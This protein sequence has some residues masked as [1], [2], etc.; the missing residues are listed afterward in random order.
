MLKETLFI[1]RHPGRAITAVSTQIAVANEFQS[2]PQGSTFEEFP[3]LRI[4]EASQLIEAEKLPNQEGGVPKN[5]WSPDDQQKLEKGEK[6][7]YYPE[8]PNV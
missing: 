4:S 5:A 7:R 1:I 2:P 8:H 3:T 6:P